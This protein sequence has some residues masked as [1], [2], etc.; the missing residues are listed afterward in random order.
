MYSDPLRAGRSGNRIPVEARFSAPT[1]LLVQYVAR[2]FSG[3]E[4]AGSGVDRIPT[5]SADVKERVQ[6]YLYF[7]PAGHSWPV[8]G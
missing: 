3:G 6:L 7:S 1:Q 2:V 5:S 4:A 8:V